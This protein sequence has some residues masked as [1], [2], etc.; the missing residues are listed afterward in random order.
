MGFGVWNLIGKVNEKKANARNKSDAVDQR[1]KTLINQST[2]FIINEAYKTARTNIMFALSATG[3]GCKKIIITSASPGEGKTTTCLNLAITFAQMNAKVLVIDADLRKPRVYRHLGLER[4]NG[5]S[6][7]LG[8]LTDINTAIHH[9]P[10]HNIDCITSGQ[11]PPNPAELLSSS[12]MEALLNTLS[13]RYDY[14]FLDTPPVTMVTEAAA[15]SKFT[16]G[17]VVIIRQNYT[18]HEMLQRAQANL[19]FGEAKILGY[20]LND[21]DVN[22]YRSGYGRYGYRGYGH[23][24]YGYGYSEYGYKYAY[25][26]GGYDGYGNKKN[27]DA[28]DHEQE[29]QTD[30]KK[31]NKK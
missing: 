19:K 28:E 2:S 12:E 31:K 1:A 29:Q 7:V 3:K 20:I 24:R 17:T 13:E 5:L 27:T 26:Y 23:R 11:I 16:N 30:E 9:C 18:I 10:E 25:H 15:M 21:V 6:D 22:Q 14:I 8:G 4:K